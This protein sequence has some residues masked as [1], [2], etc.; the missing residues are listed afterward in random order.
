MNMPPQSAG[1]GSEHRRTETGQQI[2]GW[3]RSTGIARPDDAWAGGVLAALARK[4]GW[5]SSLVRGL[6]VVALILFTSPT[7]LFYGLGWLL[8]P[9]ARSRIHAQEA[10]RGSYP[11]GL[12][13]AGIVTLLGAVNVFTPNVVGPFAILLNLV[14]IGVVGWV[15]WLLVKN[16]QSG[17]EHPNEPRAQAFRPDSEEGTAAGKD[18]PQRK[19][20]REDGKPAWYPKETSVPEHRPAQAMSVSAERDPAAEGSAQSAPRSAPAE[21]EHHRRRRLVTY[22]LL[23]LAVPAVAAAAWLAT[24]LGLATSSA[25]LLGL[26]AVVT[27]LA[28]MHLGAAVR[29]TPGRGGLLALFTGLMM[30]VYFIAP[31]GETSNHVFGNYTTSSSEVNTAFGNTVVDLRHL[32]FAEEDAL[33]SSRLGPD[34]QL[35][36]DSIH[37]WVEINNAFGNTTV[38]VPDDVYIEVDPNMLFGNVEIDTVSDQLGQ[39]GF[40][41]DSFGAGTEEAIGAV[42]IDA[43]NAFGNITVYDETTY[44]QQELDGESAEEQLEEAP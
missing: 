9:D 14:I 37:S 30:L 28:L 19:P 36:R 24:E 16:H 13:G 12:W 4:M 17:S 18:R 22:G 31:L 39:S 23:L 11:S 41:V 25:V 35:P 2:F 43:N 15:I 34:G 10:V 40:G 29:G 7:L 6:G 1:E 38:V 42:G 3:V 33:D 26:A 8:L 27:L 32:T 20:V 5:D 44:S 21:T